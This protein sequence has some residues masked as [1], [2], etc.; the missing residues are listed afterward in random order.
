METN[1]TEPGD[2]HRARRSFSTESG[3][4]SEGFITARAPKEP[5]W[6]GSAAT[7]CTTENGIPI[8]WG[9]RKSGHSSALGDGEERERLHP[10]PGPE[11]APLP[12][13]P[14][15]GTGDSVDRGA[16]KTSAS[17][18][19]SRGAHAVG[20]TSPSIQDVR[21]DPAHG[22]ASLRIGAS[23]HRVLP[24][25]GEGHRLRTPRDPGPRRQRAEGP[26]YTPPR[27]TPEA[28]GAPPRARAPSARA[29]RPGRSRLR[30]APIMPLPESTPP[31]GAT[32]DG[33]GSSRQRE[34]T[35]SARA[36]N[37]AGI[38]STKPSSSAPSNAPAAPRAS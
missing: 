11:R 15:P 31:P 33:S 14:H 20:G 3:T 4:K 1:R 13:S 9:S 23:P 7:S 12:L 21:H 24:P 28:A 37:A 18:A 38:T 19:T 17:G 35:P 36:A 10:G 16:R 27:P 26:D 34:F 6:D 29:R 30:G 32:G 5:T 2:P 8:R 22:R 25:S